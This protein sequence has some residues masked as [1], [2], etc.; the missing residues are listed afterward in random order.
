[1]LQYYLPGIFGR[2]IKH[3]QVI[4]I[5]RQ[6]VNTAVTRL[7]GSLLRLCMQLIWEVWLRVAYRVNDTWKSRPRI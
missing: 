7:G 5:Y 6:V 3:I 1:M 4:R 2:H